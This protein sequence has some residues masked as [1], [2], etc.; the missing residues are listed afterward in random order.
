MV[1][2]AAGAAAGADP[3]NQVFAEAGKAFVRQLADGRYAEANGMFDR[4]MA[5]AVSLEALEASWNDKTARLGTLR[6][7]GEPS[8]GSY[9]QYKLVFVPCEWT[10]GRL[11]VKVV[12]NPDK[13]VSGYFWVKPTSAAVGGKPAYLD[14]TAIVEREVTVGTGAWKLPG[15]LSLPKPGTPT[16]GIVLVHGS[17]PQDRDE[18]IGPNKPFRDLAFGLANHGIATL[19]YDKRTHVHKLKMSFVSPTVEKEVIEDA[20]LALQ[21]IRGQDE[22]DGVPTFILGHSLGAALAPEIAARDGHVAG[23]VLLAGPARPFWASL[24]DQYTYLCS[25]GHITE[26]QLG[27]M[28]AQAERMRGCRLRPGE[29]V[30]GAPASY[31]YDLLKHD[32]DAAVRTAAALNCGML[33]LQGARDYQVTIDD[34]NRWRT[35]LAKHRDA[36]F[37]LF[38]D[39][40]HLFAPGE[41]TATPDEY[42]GDKVHV[43]PRVI[44]LIAEWCAASRRVKKVSKPPKRE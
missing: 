41:G 13:Q 31:M 26:D 24:V 39:L 35:G 16:A 36:T 11:R 38:D 27:K 4:T 33:V 22:L 37:R 5:R 15:T 43:D 44:D 28:R 21:A 20:L 30:L 17:G 18:T 34:F 25:I 19:R 29:R 23:A 6:R 3:N 9:L 32:G 2:L 1:C 40:N 8:V 7:I 12:L 10:E 42:L 14:T